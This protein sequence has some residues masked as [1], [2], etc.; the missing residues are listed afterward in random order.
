[1]RPRT[2]LRHTRS[3]P[4]RT[5]I[6]PP[7]HPSFVGMSITRAVPP[8]LGRKP[9]DGGPCRCSHHAVTLA[10]GEAADAAATAQPTPCA[11][12]PFEMLRLAFGYAVAAVGSVRRC[13][14]AL[15]V[16]ARSG[17][18][19]ALLL[20][21]LDPVPGLS[22]RRA[23]GRRRYGPAHGLDGACSRG[24]DHVSGDMRAALCKVY[25]RSELHSPSAS[26]TA[27]VP[28]KTAPNM[29]AGGEAQAWSPP[30]LKRKK[31]KRKG[32]WT[33]LS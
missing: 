23:A 26:V 27:I 9:S 18:Y 14:R 21:A 30:W 31:K 16:V 1:M 32:L 13:K 15:L 6:C 20:G 11:G 3:G 25:R 10:L 19:R 2:I 28:T 33:V 29:R 17:P 5:A 22:Q 7:R 12:R 4:V 8:S 24:A